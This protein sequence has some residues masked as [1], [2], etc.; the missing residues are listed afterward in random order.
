MTVNAWKICSIL[1]VLLIL[2]VSA[3]VAKNDTLKSGDSGLST[4]NNF[5]VHPSV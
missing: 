5:C 4:V 1:S 2:S 3:D